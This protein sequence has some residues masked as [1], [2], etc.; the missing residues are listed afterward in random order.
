VI[1][2]TY[3]SKNVLEASRERIAYLF[4]NFERVFASVSYGKDST[5]MMHLV[6]EEARRRGRKV[7][8]LLVDLEG[9]YKLT[10]NHARRMNKM[11]EDCIELYWV[12]LPLH[13]RNSVSVYNPF[14]KCWNPKQEKAWIRE[15][16]K[17]AISNT[18]HF[19]F[20]RDGME[21]EEFI[22]KFSEWYAEGKPTVC[23]VGIRTEES[24]NRWRTIASRSK[25][26]F[27]SKQ[28]TTKSTEYV[29]N[30]YPIYDWKVS[31][32]WAYHGKNP[33]KPHNILYDYMYKAGVPLKDQRICQPYGD[34]QR[35]GLWLFHLIEPETWS[36]V[37]ARVNGANGGAQYIQEWGNIN[38]YRGITK[39]EGH[40]WESFAYLLLHSMPP[41]TSEH[42]KNKIWKFI[43]WWSKNGYPD[44]IPDEADYTLEQSKKAPSWRRICKSLLR[45]DFWFKSNGF[46]QTKSDAYKKYLEFMKEKRKTKDWLR[47][48]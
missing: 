14:W 48:G 25:T 5:V 8:I 23:L 9:Q 33:D 47:E 3:L 6:C 22:P 7:G 4:D 44:G 18:R 26:T 17:E 30:A 1:S 16:P 34:D 15:L 38:G 39:P 27:N 46:A 19:P 41:K 11:Y 21:F 43:E 32:I 2:K 37:V 20:F 45:N 10:I 13:L 28:W 40:T 12:C 36:R 42:Y 31:D 24:L 35:K 29:Y